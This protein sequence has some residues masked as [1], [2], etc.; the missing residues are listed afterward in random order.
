MDEVAEKLHPRRRV[1][2]RQS[3]DVRRPGRA[4]PP[5]GRADRAGAGRADDPPAARASCAAA[6]SMRRAD[7]TC[8]RLCRRGPRPLAGEKGVTAMLNDVTF[9]QYYPTRS[10]VHNMDPRAKIVFVI[11]YIVAVF[12]ADNFFA[13][14]A[15]TLFLVPCRD[16]LPRP[17]R[18]GAALGED[19]P[20]P[21]RLHGCAQPLL[22]S[23]ESAYEPLWKWGIVSVTWESIVN[24]RLF[25]GA[26][27]PARARHRHPDA[28]DDAPSP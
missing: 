26:P 4:V 7:F 13:L 27:V 24:A 5:R 23:G 2:R 14:A 20:V 15:V 6:A 10:F 28:D 1:R 3:G 21:G 8:A 17:S 16:L 25:G 22:S 9:G 11:A 19:D 18:Q 12:L